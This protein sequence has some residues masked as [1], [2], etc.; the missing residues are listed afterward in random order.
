MFESGVF[1]DSLKVARVLLKYKK[2]NRH[3]CNNYRQI[4]ILNSLSKIFEKII[5]NRIND[6]FE[7]NHL[8]D[9]V[10]FGFRKNRS[11]EMAI[12][13]LTN[14]INKAS[15][16]KDYTMLMSIDLVWA[17]DN[18]D[19][20]VLFSKLGSYGL[21]GP[22]YDLMVSYLT[23]RKQCT[24]INNTMSKLSL[25]HKGVPQG[26]VLGPILFVIFLNDI[27]NVKGDLKMIL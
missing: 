5:S 23:N 1:P 24:Q 8:I 17:F 11:T 21:R 7:K 19:H 9:N 27:V 20:D 13:S 6:F 22:V 16:N 3:D 12:L 2:G 15:N 4:S 18:V 25:I 26:S 14:A 10:Q